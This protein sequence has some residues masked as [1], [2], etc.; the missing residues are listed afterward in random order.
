MAYWIELHYLATGAISFWS[1]E[2]RRIE[3]D[4]RTHRA[5]VTAAVWTPSGDRL[6]TADEN[7]KVRA[8]LQG[9]VRQG[10]GHQMSSSMSQR[11]CTQF[12]LGSSWFLSRWALE[13]S[14]CL[15]LHALERA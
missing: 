14:R 4:S 8:N 12:V 3:E 15:L 13:C 1:F 2:E 10:V 7:G 6:F 5:P 11:V 9:S